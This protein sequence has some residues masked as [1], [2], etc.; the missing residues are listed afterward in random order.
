MWGFLLCLMR[1]ANCPRYRRKKA[2]RRDGLWDGGRF[3]A[4]PVAEA[5]PAHTA[6]DHLSLL[7]VARSQDFFS[8]GKH[9]STTC[10]AASVE[11]RVSQDS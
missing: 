5:D 6:M 4:E 9:A 8:Q 3:D 1:F 11:N 10:I 2:T 7:L